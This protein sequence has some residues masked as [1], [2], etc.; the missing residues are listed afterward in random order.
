MSSET[1]DITGIPW[2]TCDEMNKCMKDY[3]ARGRLVN[4]AATK[5]FSKKPGS[6][7]LHMRF[8]DQALLYLTQCRYP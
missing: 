6:D 2:A 8:T 4:H 1:A 5:G 3:E 7:F